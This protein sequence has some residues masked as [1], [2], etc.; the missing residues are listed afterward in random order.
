MNQSNILIKISLFG[1]IVLS[2]TVI[3]DVCQATTKSYTANDGLVLVSTGH[4]IQ[5]ITNCPKDVIPAYAIF[6]DRTLSVALID[7]S[8]GSYQISWTNDLTSSSS[9]SYE[10]SIY[11]ENGY[12][13]YRK[14]KRDNGNAAIR[15]L[16]MLPFRHSS[17]YSGPIVRTEFAVLMVTLFL[18]Y[19]AI[20]LRFKI[21]N[22]KI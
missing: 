10:I 11:D 18:S 6:N 13:Q 22:K 21:M 16:F 9:G 15:P 3:A 7:E 14:A 19:Y 17:P 1:L 12:Q 2:S 8:T 4:V 5:F 20:T